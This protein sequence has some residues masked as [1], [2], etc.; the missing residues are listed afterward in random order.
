MILLIIIIIL[1]I[2]WTFLK[3]AS[4]ADDKIE[5]TKNNNK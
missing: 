3:A 1:F 4:I 2:L 5:K